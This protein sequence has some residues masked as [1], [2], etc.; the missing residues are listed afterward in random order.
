MSELASVLGIAGRSAE[1]RAVAQEAITLYQAK[2]NAASERR[3]REWADQL[4]AG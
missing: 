4:P 3:V 2:G 1:A